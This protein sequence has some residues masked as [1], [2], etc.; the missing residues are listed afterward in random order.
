MIILEFKNKIE[1][2]NHDLKQERRIKWK[3]NLEKKKINLPWNDGKILVCSVICHIV[4]FLACEL[5]SERFMGRGRRK[6]V[7][8]FQGNKNRGVED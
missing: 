1:G 2:K 5:R 8:G 4:V 3:Y 7:K 6:K